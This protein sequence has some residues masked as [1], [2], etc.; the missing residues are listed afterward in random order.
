MTLLLVSAFLNDDE[1]ALRGFSAES[2]RVQRQLESK[3]QALPQ[4]DSMRETMRILSERPHHL[5]SARDSVN[6]DWILQKFRAWGLD[7]QIE[8]FQVLFPTPKERVV[9]L[10]APH[11]FRAA[12]KEPALKEDPSTSQQ[13]EQLPTYNA[14]SIDGDVTAPLVFVNYG[15]P[16]DYERLKR[17]GVSVKGAI[18][19]AKYGRSSAVSPS[20]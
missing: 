12:L 8:T 11:T 20:S 13:S 15:I 18:V 19:I 1:P 2:S 4:P 9:E 5:G 16:E 7:A 14:F 17:L 10:V 3:F 6:A